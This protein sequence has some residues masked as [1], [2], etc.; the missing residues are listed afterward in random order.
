VGLLS[1]YGA[2][3]CGV[4]AGGAESAEPQ[5]RGPDFTR[6]DV[7]V[8]WN[9]VAADTAQAHDGLQDFAV[10]VRAIT[11][12]HLAVHDALNSILAKYER[13]VFAG[14]LEARAQPTAA[15]AQAAHDVLASLYPA[16]QAALDKALATSLAPV[17]DGSA[18][19]LGVQLGKDAAAVIL[20]ERT[21]DGWEATGSYAPKPDAKPGDYRFVPPFDFFFRPGFV[22]ARPFAI[23]DRTRFRG[24]PP[25]ELSS[26]AYAAAYAEVKVFGTAKG[27]SRSEDQ[28]HEARW[29][30]EYAEGGWN[31]IANLLARQS[32]M[33]LYPATRMFALL[34]VGIADAYLAVWDAKLFHD[35]WRPYTAI[36]AGD[37]DGN[38]A[39]APDPSWE[40]FCV[41]PPV[42]EYPSAHGL[43]SA[44]AA[45]MLVAAFGTDEISLTVTSPTAPPER[46]ERTFTSLR[47]AAA[48]A[49]DSRVM[50]GIHFRFAT[51]A[52]LEQG[53]ALAGSVLERRLR[54][55]R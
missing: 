22:K 19:E 36:R 26:P 12:M 2:L 48:E 28:S 4:K 46:P 33:E 24:G 10:N 20:A 16:Q 31:R 42:S 47:R 34:N 41:T 39:T 35:R 11:M 52:G 53:R 3:G 51:D 9:Q 37:T 13:Y 6:N 15:A 40:P 44:A 1:A 29:W 5:A 49:A 54:P 43:Q 45:E 7:V 25:P 23:E 32:D 17:P 27:S 21:G 38:D 18:K 8:T 50:C 55:E 30:Y 14:A